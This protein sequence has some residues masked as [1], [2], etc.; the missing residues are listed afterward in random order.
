M[1]SVTESKKAPRTDAVPAAL[2]TGPSNR[3][4]IPVMIRKMMAMWKCPDATRTAVAVADTRPVAGE[5]VSGD[6]MAM[7]CLADRTGGPVDGCSPTT[8]EHEAPH[9]APPR[10]G[11][12]RCKQKFTIR[13]PRVGGSEGESRAR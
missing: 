4:C 3:S 2:A 10:T 1:R 13:S 7:Q 12:G 5:D 8:V 6:A 11:C 9:C